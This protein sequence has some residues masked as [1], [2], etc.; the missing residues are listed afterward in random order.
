MPLVTVEQA[1]KRLFRVGLVELRGTFFKPSD[2][3]TVYEREQPSDAVRSFHKGML[4]KSLKALDEQH[5][6]EKDN[7]GLVFAID[8]DDLPL[9]RDKIRKFWGRELSQIAEANP[10]KNKVY[11]LSI[12]LFNLTGEKK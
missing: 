7:A 9:Y 11:A 2:S 1:F 5:F 4:E 6:E 3:Q 8:P 10:K 12:S